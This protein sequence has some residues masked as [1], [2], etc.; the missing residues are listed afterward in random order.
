VQDDV[1]FESRISAGSD[2]L[3][4]LFLRGPAI[5]FS[6]DTSFGTGFAP[7]TDLERLVYESEKYLNSPEY[8]KAHPEVGSDIKVMGMRAK[9]S[10]KLTVACAFISKHVPDLESYVKFKQRVHDDLQ[11]LCPKLTQNEVHIFVNTADDVENKSVYITLTGTS[12]EMGDDGSVGRGNRVSGLITP[13]RSMTMEAAAGKNPVNH[14]GKI[15]AVLASD[16][17]SSVAT[18]HPE[19]V[20]VTITLLSQIGKPIDQPKV[21]AVS[22]IAPDQEY[23]RISAEVRRSIDGRLENITEVTNKIVEGKL[24]IF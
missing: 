8:K 21:A 7:F 1:E 10:I 5:P 18:E 4:E 14:V 17:A 9:D 20:D 13:M 2:D 23:E 16:I 19:V 12:A 3:V 15:Y 11:K 6:N 22:I 24:T